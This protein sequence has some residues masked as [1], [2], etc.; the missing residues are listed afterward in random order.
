MIFNSASSIYKVGC[1][2]VA[3]RHLAAP[4]VSLFA[5]DHG[6]SSSFSLSCVG[7]GRAALAARQLWRMPIWGAYC[8]GAMT[9]SLALPLIFE[10]F[11]GYTIR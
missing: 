10:E 9:V 11:I 8:Q 5:M 2:G 4:R 1:S 3:S 7:G 6:V